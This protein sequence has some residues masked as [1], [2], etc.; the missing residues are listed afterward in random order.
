MALDKSDQRLV[1]GAI[2]GAVIFGVVYFW[3]AGWLGLAGYSALAEQE[4]NAR[5]NLKTT[6]GN[7][8]TYHSPIQPV[9]YGERGEPNISSG[10]DH[11]IE[12]LKK[13]YDDANEF[14]KAKIEEKQSANRIAY[15]TWTETDER[16]PGLYFRKTWE[17]HRNV[18]EIACKN[19]HVEVDDADIGFK[20]ISGNI[21]DRDKALEF[22]RELY[23]AERIIDLCIQAKLAEENR[24]R[25]LGFKPEAYM[26]IMLVE[27][28][29]SETT[30]PTALI[31]NPKYD[32]A[33]K[34][35][36]SA[37]FRKFNV[38]S[39]PVFIQ[40]YPVKIQLICDTNTFIQFM[41]SV[42]TPKDPNLE[43]TGV[44]PINSAWNPPVN[45]PRMPQLK[46]RD[47]GKTMD[48]KVGDYLPDYKYTVTKIDPLG[49]TFA[50]E[51]GNPVIVLEGQFL[52]FR[53][54]EILSP[55]FEHSNRDKTELKEFRTDANDL[56]VKRRF[57]ERSEQILVTMIAAGM[58]FFDP[59]EKP[60]GFYQKKKEVNK[61]V[62]NRP[63]RRVLGGAAK[64]PQ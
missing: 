48:V 27:P 62:G 64:P 45:G 28:R 32:P 63:G 25:S 29:D 17:N 11:P 14:T 42:R 16:D 13:L 18:V 33:E 8:D 30:G 40:E 5:A 43:F 46:F 19:A 55:S 37:K 36:S 56:Q 21:P 1:N 53:Q 24:E 22:L 47:S 51:H 41:H 38:E 54:L 49:I 58:D 60:G 61:P 57:P 31:P 3:P 2:I 44:T 7:Y 9:H 34:N 15:P 20:R 23:I 4:S 26:R 39:W 35:P 52:V 6:G 59:I 12:G 10:D 50:D